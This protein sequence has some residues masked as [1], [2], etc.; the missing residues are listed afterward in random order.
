MEG[1]AQV[2]IP[3]AGPVNE[4]IAPERRAGVRCRPFGRDEA[5][6]PRR[7]VAVDCTNT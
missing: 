4:V 1:P 2:D 3:R 7:A 6:A 5:R